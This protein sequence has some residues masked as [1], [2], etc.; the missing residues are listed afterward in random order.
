VIRFF[1]VS[2]FISL[3]INCQ[4]SL[5]SIELKCLSKTPRK[6]RVYKTEVEGCLKGSYQAFN[7]LTHL[8]LNECLLNEPTDNVEAIFGESFIQEYYQSNPGE[9]SI[10]R[11]VYQTDTEGDCPSSSNTRLVFQF[12]SLTKKI[13]SI[14]FEGM[15]TNS[16]Y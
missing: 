8:Y 6:Y 1:G 10:G 7:G 11:L 14:N 13:F 16:D 5:T 3:L 9:T 2:L 12:D 15:P 4:S